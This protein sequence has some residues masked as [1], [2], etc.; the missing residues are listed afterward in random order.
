[1]LQWGSLEPDIGRLQCAWQRKEINSVCKGSGTARFFVRGRWWIKWPGTEF[2]NGKLLAMRVEQYLVCYPHSEHF[3]PCPWVPN[4]S[5]TL[6]S[7]T[8]SKN[9][10][11]I[12]EFPWQYT[13]YLRSIALN[14]LQ[15][16]WEGTVTRRWGVGGWLKL[17]HKGPWM[18]RRIRSSVLEEACWQ[19]WRLEGGAAWEKNVCFLKKKLT[20]IC[21]SALQMNIRAS[22]AHSS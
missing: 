10:S 19:M 13:I 5:S 17:H 18:Q 21:V 8:T 2:L 7:L 22:A 11:Y 14:H 1:M 20:W 12:C 4:A 16:L 3:A 6:Q 15:V 9:A